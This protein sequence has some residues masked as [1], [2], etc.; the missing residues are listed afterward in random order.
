MPKTIQ[1]SV[2]LPAPPAKL[3]RMYLDPRSHAAIT[4]APVEVG[5]R[6]GSAFRAFGGALSGRILYTRPGR[7]IVQT[8]RSK[9]FGRKDL[10]SVLVLTFTPRGRSGRIQLVHANVADRDARGVTAGWKTYYWKPWRAYLRK[11]R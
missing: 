9:G 7:M 1:Q 5:A 3:Y 11:K 8:W 10:D 4:G 6:P 2:T